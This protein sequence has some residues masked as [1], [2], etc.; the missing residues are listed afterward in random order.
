ML[1][2]L[3]GGVARSDATAISGDGSRIV[4]RACTD[5]G[6]EAFIYDAAGGMRNLRKTLISV[7]GLGD[8][9]STWVLTSASGISADGTVIVGNGTN[10]WAPS[11]QAWI[12]TVPRC[13][14]DYDHDGAFTPADVSAFI[15]AWFEGLIGGTD[16]GDFDL[17]GTVA[18]ADIAAFVRAWYAAVT[19]ACS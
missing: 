1:G 9:L 11:G 5:L 3:P 16:L 14:G 12:A 17:D 2:D 7:Y 13:P 8:S 4:G 19:G 18:P 6:D 10:Y 15:G